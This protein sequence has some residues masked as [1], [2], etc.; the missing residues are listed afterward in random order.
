MSWADACG[1]L[2][3]LPTDSLRRN[4]LPRKP[5]AKTPSAPTGSVTPGTITLLVVV[6]GGLSVAPALFS[7]LGSSAIRLLTRYYLAERALAA[8]ET[9]RR[10]RRLRLDGYNGTALICRC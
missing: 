6:R 10:M 5:A 2:A 7:V 8:N 9:R 1:R 4:E 3:T